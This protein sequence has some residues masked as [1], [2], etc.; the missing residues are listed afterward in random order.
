MNCFHHRILKVNDNY[1]LPFMRACIALFLSL[2]PSLLFAQKQSANISG[3]VLGDNEEPLAGVSV[4]ILGKMS[5]LTTSDSGTFS[6]RVPS[7][8]ALALSFSHTGYRETQRNFFLSPG[9]NEYIIIHL[10]PSGKTL[11]SVIITD[12]RERQEN[13]LVKINP[14]NALMLPGPTGGVEGIIKT[15]TGSN[16]ELTGQYSVRGGNYDEN[17]VYINDIEIFRPYLVSNAQ[18]EGLSLINPELARSVSFQ[19]GG[20]QA[21]YGDK[22]SSVLD[23]QYKKPSAFGGMAYAGL[24]E[25]GFSLEGASRNGRFTAIAGVRNKSNKNLLSSQPTAGSYIPSSSDVQ[26]YLTGKISSR[27]QVEALG[28]FSSTRFSFFPEFVRKTAS[29]FTPL[30]SLNL[31]L[32]VFF[33]GSEKDRYTTSLGAL[34]F[35]HTPGKNLRIKWIFSRF[36]DYEKENFD[37]GG[38]YIFGERD[39]DA[40]SS[41][42]GEIVNPLGAGYYQ[43]YGRNKLDIRVLSAAHRGSLHAGRH[44]LQ[45]GL[46]ADET[47]ISDRLLQ[48]E[49]RDSAGY[50]LPY[51][52]GSLP[53]YQSQSTSTTLNLQRYSGFLQDNIRLG[54]GENDIRIQGGVRFNYNTLNKEWLISPR[55][56]ASWA[57]PGKKDIIFRLAAGMYD[58]PPFYREL[59]D[60]DARLN[61]QIKAQRSFQAVA[62]AD[63]DLKNE[64][65]PL[66]IT[67]EIYYKRISSLIPY[68]IDNVK[69]RYLGTNNARGYV[70]G[71]EVRLF[72]QLLK[73]AESWFS[74]GYMQAR[75]NLDDDHYFRYLNAAGEVIGP[76]TPDKII[77]DSQRVDIGWLRRPSDRRFTM[78]LFLQDYLA[79]NRNFRVNLNILYG[80]NM[81]Y[82][83]PGSVRFRNALTIDPYIRV[84][85]GFS[86]LLLDEKSLRRSHSPF[87]ALENLWLSLE[88]FNL[89]N[90][91]NIISYQLISDFAGNRFAIPNRLTPRLLSFKLAAR[92]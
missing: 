40:S 46:T 17:L 80:S 89:I 14:K 31:G 90:R 25:Q 61:T 65:R 48:W 63:L 19:S 64:K 79:T 34:T 29:V 91:A 9:E 59:R 23:I 75:E 86:A 8:K 45:W 37:I 55:A 51:V 73:D 62:G 16:N 11:E 38:S 2:I 12:R 20:F 54:K 1:Y 57:P 35:S 33:E 71:A 85:I 82:N 88:V 77:A 84:D 49:Y 53:F 47:G 76:Q 78:G 83:I 18:Q 67:S 26:A 4:S 13:S 68:D 39:F 10:Q 32:D 60:Y 87:R 58:Q 27:W 50:S 3:L 69:I 74:F 56:S 81:S 5:G 41:S 7:E 15:F 70:T 22:I 44:D 52:P 92:F 6:I 43:Q 24:M 28:I 30:Y 36:R 42:F 21:K 72:A 66:R